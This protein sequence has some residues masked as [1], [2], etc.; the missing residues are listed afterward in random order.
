VQSLPETGLLAIR[1]GGLA[2]LGR[3]AKLSNG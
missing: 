2:A 1:A 3:Y